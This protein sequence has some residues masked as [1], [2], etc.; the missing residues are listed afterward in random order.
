M[1][2]RYG[3]PAGV[4]AIALIVYMRT[5]LPG[6]AFDDWG[7]MQVVPHVLGIPHPTGYPTYVLVA[8][9][10]ELLP[11]GSIAFRAN[12]LSAVCIAVALAAL[13]SAQ[14]RLGVRPVVA[15]GAALATGF[16][17]SIWSSATVAEVNA[18]HLA[19]VGLHL[20]PGA[21]LGAGPPLPG[22]RARRPAHRPLDGQPRPHRLHRALR[23]PVRPVDRAAD[24][25]RAQGVD[26]GPR[27]HDGPRRPRVPV[28]ADRR[29]PRPAT[30]L[31]HPRRLRQLQVPG[32]WAS[33]SAASTGASSRR[34]GR[35]PSSPRCPI[36]A[37]S[38]ASGPRSCSHSSRCWASCPRSGATRRSRRSSWRRSSPA[39]TSGPTTCAWST[40]SWCRGSRWA[41]SSGSRSTPPATSSR[42]S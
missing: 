28:P 27:R 2:G 12:L 30:P 40:T 26:P 23:D 15:A 20:R 11:I 42:A 25:R 13:T 17:G 35:A 22:S 38:W 29:E 19:F 33:S 3:A 7:E 31:Q 16:T 1:L 5:L 9:L 8:W 21:G 36:S 18:L 37:S 39:S 41:S 34:R 32:R 14:Q 4:F 24:A 6:Q 10:F